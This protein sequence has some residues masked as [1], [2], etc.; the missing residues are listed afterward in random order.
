MTYQLK[1]NEGEHCLHGGHNGFHNSLWN[2]EPIQMKDRVSVKLTHRFIE[3]KSGFP[4]NLDA[5]ITY[6]L[7]N[8][9]QF[10]I[11]YTF[12]S[13]KRTPLTSTNHSYF[14][15]SGNNKTSIHDHIVML[16]SHHFV[17]LDEELIP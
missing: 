11:D 10:M 12:C 5:E 14:N 4:G 3:E 16:D 7:N 1:P 9:N 6:T 13:D 15:L 2:I 17:E 8:D